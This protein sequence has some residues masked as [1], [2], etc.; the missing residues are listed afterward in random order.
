MPVS[1]ANNEVI[2]CIMRKLMWG[3][4][5][6]GS[7]THHRLVETGLEL[8]FLYMYFFSHVPSLL[9][10]LSLTHCNSVT[11]SVPA[12]CDSLL[13]LIIINQDRLPFFSLPAS[14]FCMTQTKWRRMKHVRNLFKDSVPSAEKALQERKSLGQLIEKR[15]RE[16]NRWGALKANYDN[17]YI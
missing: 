12:G 5:T 4:K 15:R 11:S 6:W 13:Y 2:R 14:C 10:L 9:L 3:S 16:G 17:F 1:Q 8:Q 7:S